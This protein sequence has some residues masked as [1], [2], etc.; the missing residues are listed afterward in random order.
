[1]Q[2]RRYVKPRLRILFVLKWRPNPYEGGSG[3]SGDWG[4]ATP[5][6]PM[7]SGLFNSAR[8]VET[9]LAGE[10]FSTKL[11]HVHDANDIHR[12]VVRFAADVVV[13]EAFWVPPYKFDDLQ[14]AS[15][16]VRFIVR[17]HSETPFLAH[18][19]IAF[20]W[21][22]E[23]LRRA[24]VSLAPNAPRML[25]ET[26]FLAEQ[27]HPDWDGAD[28][29]R[30]IPLLPNYYPV[31]RRTYRPLDRSKGVLD[32]GCFGA[33]RPMKNHMLQAIAA[34][35]TADQ[36]G[37]AL[38][39]HI[40]GM[41]LEMGGSPVLKN[42]RAIF[43]GNPRH[44]LVEHPWQP[45][46]GFRELVASMDLVAQVSFTETFN[47]VAADA[48]SAGVPVVGSTEIPWLHPSSCAD[49]SR[50]EDIANV[51]LR[52]YLRRRCRPWFNPD[53]DGIRAYNDD[54]RQRW[55]CYLGSL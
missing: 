8:L 28:L 22:T 35:M 23:Y 43:E 10:G 1:M 20:G 45:H 14:R 39:F 15:P 27:L 38:R 54:S 18:E 12:E 6:R 42:L 17:N 2:F 44:Q 21:S 52:L 34:M 50:A 37:L 40:N 4:D 25:A 55:L 9:M 5:D 16:K 7:S 36:L 30:R 46:D 41:R 31:P 29:A 24:N 33:I 32:V 47:I 51:M 26:R 48:I 49:P 53:L 13:I 11:V 19:G 3:S